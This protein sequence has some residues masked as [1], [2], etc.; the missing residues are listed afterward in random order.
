MRLKTVWICQDCLSVNSYSSEEPETFE[1]KCRAC[2]A[3]HIVYN[4]GPGRTRT[5]KILNEEMTN[6]E[7]S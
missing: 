7:V 3:W 1:S 6:D 2:E 5:I 4:R